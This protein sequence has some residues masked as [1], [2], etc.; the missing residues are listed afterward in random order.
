[1]NIN[2]KEFY[3]H[4]L[5]TTD[6]DIGHVKDLYFDDTTWAV[7]Y[8]VA[9]TGTWLSERQ[10]LLSPNAF[11]RWDREAQVLHVK[12]TR[13]QI[14]GSPL[15]ETHRP[16]SRQHE[17]EY[18]RYYGW[19][20][21]WDGGGMWGMAGF[22]L[23]TPPTGPEANRHHGHNQRD[24]VHLR[25]TKAVTGYHIEATDGAIGS[26][27][28]FIVDVKAWV[29]RDIV[30]EAGHW[31]SGKEILIPTRSIERICYNESKVFVTLSKADI[32]R[33]EEHEVVKAG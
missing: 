15:I 25:S 22:P 26:V 17:E 14:E 5:H 20:G 18:Y 4:T 9:E 7:R 3:S 32:Q 19:P 28:G 33:T 11:G 23:V 2:S 10:V 21:Y 1:M 13:K 16:V 24:D 29:V 6:G 27:S 30:V 31:Y 12:L 8:L